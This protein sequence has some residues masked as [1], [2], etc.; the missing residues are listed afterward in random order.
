[1]LKI[2]NKF[3]HFCGGKNQK[4]FYLSILL[5][6]FMALFEALKIP[7]IVLMLDAVIKGRVTTAVIWQCFGICLMSVIGGFIVKYFN[8]MTHI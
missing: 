6:V 1:M 4:K 3:F 7:A 8:T 5:G 2:L